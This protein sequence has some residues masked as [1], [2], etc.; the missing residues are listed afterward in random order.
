MRV[1]PP[2]FWVSAFQQ[3]HPFFFNQRLFMNSANRQMHSDFINEQ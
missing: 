2:A 1:D 3:P